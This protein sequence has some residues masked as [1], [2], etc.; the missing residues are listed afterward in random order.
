MA[1]QPLNAKAVAI[2][3]LDGT[4][5]V[6][7]TQVLMVRFLR[8]ARVVNW[9]F[10]LGTALWFLV[11]KAGLVKVTQ[12]SRAKGGEVLAGLSE[13][14]VTALMARFTEEEM[15]PRLHPAAVAALA[16]HQAEGDEVVVVSAALQPLVEALCRWLGVAHYAGALCQIVDGRYT[17]RLLGAIPYAGEKARVAERFIAEYGADPADC[18]AYADHDTDLELLRFVGHP[19]AVNPRPGLRSEAERQGWPI[20]LNPYPGGARNG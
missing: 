12:A 10:V 9:A 15:V 16:E 20:L 14:E 17:G 11:Y 3:D 7:Q 18:W 1:K 13:A 4:L 19:V 5:V 6:G 2:F 8:K